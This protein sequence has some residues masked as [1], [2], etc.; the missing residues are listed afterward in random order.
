[1]AFEKMLKFFLVG[2]FPNGAVGG[3][4]VN[5]I[6]SVSALVF[7][8]VFGMLL[9]LGRLSKN[10]A[11]SRVC[12]VFIELCRALPLL[13]IM[14]WFVLTIPLIAGKPLPAL[15]TAFFAIALYSSVNQAEIFRAGVSSVDKGQWLAAKS[16]GLSL[17]QCLTE[18]VLP[19]MF[20]AV[21]PSY[22]GFFISLF[23]DTSIVT[24]VGLIDLTYA[25]V[26]VSQRYPGQMFEC[27]ALMAV[28]FFV[29]CLALSKFSKRI[30]GR[31]ASKYGIRGC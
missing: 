2:P 30:E 18:V 19:Q 12:T 7:G 28:I 27:Y 23:K 1:M 29:I 31:F 16:T 4:L 9:A 17:V 10:R 5:V 24:M 26:M 6:L 20:R 3:L 25:G 13:L 8:F 14:F 15:L 11:L 22:V 21:L